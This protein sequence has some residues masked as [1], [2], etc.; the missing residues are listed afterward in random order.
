MNIYVR[1]VSHVSWSYCIIG[2]RLSGIGGASCCLSEYCVQKYDYE[3]IRRDN[4]VFTLSGHWQ[5]VLSARIIAVMGSDFSLV[6]YWWAVLF[7]FGAVAFPLTRRIFALW[8]DEGYILAKAVGMSV[9]TY[10]VYLL[11]T[12]QLVP[13]TTVTIVLAMAGVFFLGIGMHVFSVKIR[14]GQL[15]VLKRPPDARRIPWDAIVFEELLFFTLLLFWSWVKA[16]EPSI[17]SLEKFM[18][19]GFTQ[20][21][22]NSTYFPAPDMWYAG[23]TINYYYFGHTVMAVLTKFSGIE[24]NYTYNLML[25]TLFALCATMSFGIAVQVTRIGFL[26]R[27]GK[28][29]IREHLGAR[30]V[31][32]ELMAGLL[33]AYLVTLAGNL[34]TVYAFTKGYTGEN[35]PAFWTLFWSTGEFWSKLP[36]GIAKYWYA[37]AT[38][39]I[40]FTIHEFPSYSFVVSDIHGHVLSI[41]FVLLAFAVLL[42]LFVLMRAVEHSQKLT[43]YI[44]TLVFYGFLVSISFMTNALDGP[45]YGG[46]FFFML[47]VSWGVGKS[48]AARVR[49]MVFSGIAVVV[50]AALTSVP[51]LLNF[52]SFVSGVGVNCPP[53]FLENR[54]FGMIIFETVDKCQHSPLWM[55]LLLWGFFLYCGVWFIWRNVR[56]TRGSAGPFELDKFFLYVFVYCLLLISF[57][58]FFYFKDIYPAH[59]R[60]N[61]MFKLGYQAFMMLG[62]LSGYTIIHVLT[63]A[64]RRIIRAVFFIGLLPL[65]VLVCIYPYFSVNSYFGNLKEY[66]GLN[67]FAWLSEQYPDDAAA[68]RWLHEQVK[69]NAIVRG[70]TPET[71][72]PVIVE[73]DGESYTDYARFSAFTGLPTIIG[74]P[75][76]EWLWRGT[77]DIV[78]PRREEVRQ[79]YE[80]GN[81]AEMMKILLKYRVQYIIVGTLERQKFERIDELAIQRVAREVFRSGQ[82][83]IYQIQ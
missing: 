32:W 2:L 14:F 63:R 42:T 39:F 65:L 78:A 77:Y 57:A 47:L 38:R 66:K 8:W 23:G 35:P 13:F 69:N 27:Q 17:H 12:A 58:E 74:W 3:P 73:A 52:K 56:V 34:Q 50:S 82:T 20:A 55:L 31:F 18:D 11:G 37:N 6:L 48:S 21:V 81:D 44:G 72:L 9:V 67:G 19:F 29:F 41:P 1:P 5:P 62:I 76:H 68:I 45:I 33:T 10:I 71:Q 22:L 60:S 61:T 28:A 46:L 43:R 53:A 26:F 79:I 64:G 59:F 54:Q 49:E 36:E 16:H 4:I 15:H 40:P 30:I 51:F 70:N 80:S 25:A 75:V 83:I 7:L 24:L